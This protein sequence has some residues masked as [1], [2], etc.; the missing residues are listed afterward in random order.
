MKSPWQLTYI[1]FLIVLLLP[2]MLKMGNPG[3]HK[4]IEDVV[5]NI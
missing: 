2:V 3:R 5:E 4:V 1:E